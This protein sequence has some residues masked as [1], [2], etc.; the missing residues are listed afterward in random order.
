MPSAATTLSAKLQTALCYDA[1]DVRRLKLVLAPGKPT[2]PAGPAHSR[3]NS[4]V[5]LSDTR[6]SR[7]TSS[8]SRDNSKTSYTA[9]THTTLTR[10]LPRSAKSEN[11]TESVTP[12]QRHRVAV[13]AVNGCLRILA[14]ASVRLESPSDPA[15]APSNSSR[16]TTLHTPRKASETH[17]DPSRRSTVEEHGPSE[18]SRE[19]LVI[20]TEVGRYAFEYLQSAEGRHAR[21]SSQSDAQVQG[22]LIS[23]VS[24][25]L[26]LGLHEQALKQLRALQNVLRHASNAVPE[27]VR[28]P[29]RFER[30][31]PYFNPTENSSGLADLLC[32]EV[33][34]VQ[35]PKLLSDIV[36]HQLLSL[37]LIVA[38]TRVS[39]LSVVLHYV[40]LSYKS[41][42][43]NIL[44]QLYELDPA[45]PRTLL[46]LDSLSKILAHTAQRMSHGQS[47]DFER[48]SLALKM[49]TLALRV[50]LIWVGLADHECDYQTDILLPF[51]RVV[52]IYAK[53]VSADH[54]HKYK[55]ARKLYHELVNQATATVEDGRNQ[56]P[57]DD[58]VLDLSRMAQDAGL[59]HEAQELSKTL[60]ASPQDDG[61]VSAAEFVEI[62]RLAT[63]TLANNEHT[64]WDQVDRAVKM[65]NA[66]LNDESSSLGS[67]MREALKLRAAAYMYIKKTLT[68]AATQDIL[69]REC[70]VVAYQTIVS[71][72]VLLSRVLGQEN[73]EDSS[74]RQRMILAA[75][76]VMKQSM[77]ATCNV[78][79]QLM[80]FAWMPVDLLLQGIA[81]CKHLLQASSSFDVDLVQEWLPH[82]DTN[83]LKSELAKLS[84]SIPAGPIPDP[85]QTLRSLKQG[86]SILD[87]TDATV[88]RSAMQA[89]GHYRF[90][91]ALLK[92]HRR[93]DARL[94]FEKSIRSCVATGIL[95][96]AAKIAEHQPTKAMLKS[97][98]ES[99]VLHAAL[100]GLLEIDVKSEYVDEPDLA[101]V[102]DQSSD[103]KALVYELCLSILCSMMASQD[104][105]FKM[106]DAASEISRLLLRIYEQKSYP[107][108]RC[109]LMSRLMRL[110][111]ERR[112]LKNVIDLEAVNDI[113]CFSGHLAR[114]EQLSTYWDHYR[115]TLSASLGLSRGSQ[116]VKQI[117]SALE[118]WTHL[119]KGAS[120]WEDIDSRIDEPE[121]CMAQLCAIADFMDTQGL[122]EHRAQAL[123]L[124]ASAEALSDDGALIRKPPRTVD[125]A[126][127]LSQ[128]GYTNE[129]GRYLDVATILMG[130]SD[131]TSPHADLVRSSWLLARSETGKR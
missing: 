17:V 96:D 2:R 37:R 104:V 94:S 106:L 105:H 130:L 129:A 33:R 5:T 9:S 6:S 89:V 82:R 107:L 35:K 28:R 29:T 90:G 69:H 92:L 50:R 114:D 118:T 58:L 124:V 41:S 55:L 49:I 14:V 80:H 109:R 77:E 43:V 99:Q 42:P 23:F 36:S 22:G 20:T 46:Q 93:T 120:S 34:D 48:V 122:D 45:N 1:E 47:A 131:G 68:S 101:F 51:S 84:W 110:R 126:A 88:R 74:G 53:V 16:G 102:K 81:L 52:A 123:A 85:L 12:Q 115:S 125:V 31:P 100:K 91:R 57:P 59:F 75:L 79:K 30:D 19:Q 61:K 21:Y 113:L 24:K 39:V 111:A 3:K 86:L 56:I 54:M 73:D 117:K 121:Q 87:D 10:P 72:L 116:G 27:E 26:S 98:P 60:T 63:F 67:V 108:R 70:V 38:S 71:F 112:E 13:D 103:E 97:H 15:N 65:L 25:L 44:V 40:D 66:G 78:T 32:F 64:E 7:A 18:L 128:L 95:A 11:D 119:I 127:H 83:S 76:R 4:A 62:A 8:T